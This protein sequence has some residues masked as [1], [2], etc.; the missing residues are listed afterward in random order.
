M[1]SSSSTSFLVLLL[2]T[3]WGIGIWAKKGRREV[4]EGNDA[5]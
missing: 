5:P 3:R 4:G 1:G 2:V